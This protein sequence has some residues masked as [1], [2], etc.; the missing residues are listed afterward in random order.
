[1]S[2]SSKS[3]DKLMIGTSKFFITLV[4]LQNEKRNY[5]NPCNL[6]VCIQREGSKA[7]KVASIMKNIKLQ[8][9]L[10]SNIGVGDNKQYDMYK[11]LGPALHMSL[12]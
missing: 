12:L 1:M 2:K 10:G 7:T 8:Q 6:V 11:L 9:S 3:N 4:K 5:L